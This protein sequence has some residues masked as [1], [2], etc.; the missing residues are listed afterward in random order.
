MARQGLAETGEI[1]KKS[2]ALARASWAVKSVYEPRL[3]ALIASRV[4][5]GDKDFQT[6]QLPIRELLGEAQD[7][8]TYQLVA[9]VIDNLMGRVITIQQHNG[10]EKYNVF[11]KCKY[12]WDKGTIEVRFDPDLKEHFLGLKSHFTKYSLFE[13]L[14]LPSIYSQRLFEILKS[15][16]DKPEVTITLQELFTILNVPKSLQRYPDFRR[17]VLEKAHKD[18]NGKTSFYYEWEPIKTGRAVSSIKFVFSSKKRTVVKK[19]NDTKQSHI[20]NKLFIAAVE[21][22]KSGECKF[23]AGSKKCDVCQRVNGPTKP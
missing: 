8:R 21:C 11:S 9:E 6:Y 20:N 18:I 7:G 23:K 15:W 1:V 19:N 14:I 13:F 22:F 10:W 3:V 4:Q 2:N 5:A 17:Y 16:D 12:D